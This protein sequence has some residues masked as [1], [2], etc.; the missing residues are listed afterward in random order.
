MTNSRPSPPSGSVVVAQGAHTV[1]PAGTVDNTRFTIERTDQFEDGVRVYKITLSTAENM[2][3]TLLVT[4]IPK[5]DEAPH[6][7]L[8]KTQNSRERIYSVADTLPGRNDG[9]FLTLRVVPVPGESSNP[10][11]S[12]VAGSPYR[13]PKYPVHADKDSDNR[14]FYHITVIDGQPPVSVNPRL[15]PDVYRKVHKSPLSMIS[16]INMW[17]SII[18]STD[19][20]IQYK[21]GDRQRD[22]MFVD[23]QRNITYFQL[24]P[25]HKLEKGK[26][27][28]WTI[29]VSTTPFTLHD[30]KHTGH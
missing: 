3:W 5:D 7:F 17:P 16:P 8:F 1:T 28:P 11:S 26:D 22:W 29:N 4:A 13:L 24:S 18:A 30:L 20:T 14:F 23:Q 6:Q 12:L 27:G 19:F 21:N 10:V 25:E 2:S 15:D 9:P